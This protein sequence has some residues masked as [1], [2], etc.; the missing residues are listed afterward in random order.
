MAMTSLKVVAIGAQVSGKGRCLVNLIKV[1]CQVGSFDSQDPQN[2]STFVSKNIQIA[3]LHC[4]NMREGCQSA[5]SSGVY[6][7]CLHMQPR[8]N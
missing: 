8:G 5:A 1:E 6:G 2:I 7:N 4:S 3:Y